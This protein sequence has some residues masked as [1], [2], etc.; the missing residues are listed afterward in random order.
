[1]GTQ[2]N[3]R[4][5]LVQL[6]QELDRRHHKKAFNRALRGTVWTLVVVA[7]VA[8]ICSTFFFSV[9]QIEGSSMEPTL[10]EGE[11]VVASKSKHFQ[12]DDIIAF[13]YNNKVLLKRVMGFPGEWINIDQDGIVYIDSQALEE[14]YVQ[15]NALGQCDI[16]LPC[17]VPEERWFVL[18]DHRATSVDSRSKVIGNVAEEQLVGKVVFRIWPLSKLGSVN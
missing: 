18:G 10:N 13:Y 3:T 2:K 8:I 15:E 12:R 14:P 6:N 5:T 1:M 11:L 17:Q 7:A 16:T 4:P 9:L